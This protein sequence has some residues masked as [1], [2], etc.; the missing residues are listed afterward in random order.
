MVL[1]DQKRQTLKDLYENVGGA[2]GAF[3]GVSRLHKTAR[4][5]D[6]S[7]LY[8]DVRRF[9]AEHSVRQ[10]HYTRS[11]R[12]DPLKSKSKRVWDVSSLGYFGIDCMYLQKA[13]AG[14]FP[15]MMIMVD[16]FSTKLYATFLKKLDKNTGLVAVKRLFEQVDYEIKGCCTDKGGEFALLHDYMTKLGK[17]YYVAPQRS[18][19][20]I[21]QGERAVRLVRQL[22]GRMLT[23]GHTTSAMQALK[24]SIASHNATPTA[25]LGDLSPNEVTEDK[26]GFVL[27]ERLK[28]RLELESK[29]VDMS[30]FKVGQLVRLKEP[31]SRFSKSNSPTYSAELYKID[32]VL[33][34]SPTPGY[35]LRS[36]RTYALLPGSVDYSQILLVS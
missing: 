31:K 21:S 17:N 16:L 20:K 5:V 30:R 3:M 6:K 10:Q 29:V 15:F 34:H 11:P 27:N 25:N 9:L 1:T 4:K 23:S 33:E 26:Q 14:P 18:L 8:S 2:A 28:R 12:A 36:E 13:L 32:S 19:N 7:I 35:R 24:S 22:A